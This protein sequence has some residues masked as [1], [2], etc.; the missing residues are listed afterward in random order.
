MCV[1]CAIL[2]L[3]QYMVRTSIGQ[4]VNAI[5]SDCHVDAV[6]MGMMSS[7]YL[8]GYSLAQLPIA[9]LCN[10]IGTRNTA[11]LGSALLTIS[12][13][14]QAAVASK[15]LMLFVRFL[16]GC[17]CAFG[18]LT[19]LQMASL[20]FHEKFAGRAIG[21]VVTAGFIGALSS[22]EI[23]GYMVACNLHW[24]TIFS[25]LAML[26]GCLTLTFILLLDDKGPYTPKQEEQSAGTLTHLLNSNLLFTAAYSWLS[27]TPLMLADYW[28]VKIS[29]DTGV[30]GFIDPQKALYIGMMCGLN[31]AGYTAD[32]IGF[33]RTMI[34][35]G[36]LNAI[37]VGLL[38]CALAM[39]LTGTCFA[40]LC[41]ALG[42]VAPTSVLPITFAALLVPKESG[43]TARAVCNLSQMLGS[44]VSSTV[45]AE[46]LC[47]GDHKMIGGTIV[48]A[49]S[50]YA[51]I[52]YILGCCMLLTTLALYRIRVN[53]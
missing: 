41:F 20:W 16:S 2:Y 32:R 40:L 38:G 3:V 12:C 44:M 28:M 34:I 52:L 1:L 19:S 24:R 18:L 37:L 7:T 14:M 45:I 9:I 53:K 23:V 21:A 17:A 42:I 29:S 39:N 43:G 27:Y 35:G 26:C 49:A 8:V 15:S 50:T 22:S 10:K 11:I 25:L 30:C 5:M 47:R 33:K 36:F 13:G 4:A 31:L 46:M 48:Y 6:F 51:S